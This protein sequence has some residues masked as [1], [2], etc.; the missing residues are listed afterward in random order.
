MGLVPEIKYLVSCIL[1][2]QAPVLSKIFKTLCYGS[3]IWDFNSTGY[4][5]ICTT[6]NIGVRTY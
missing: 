5:K 4:R 3:P 1:Y 6:E 2:L